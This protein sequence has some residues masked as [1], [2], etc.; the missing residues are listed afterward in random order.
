MSYNNDM[1]VNMLLLPTASGLEIID[2][3]SLVRVE[4][5]SNYSRLFFA[6]GKTL[7]VAKVLAWFEDQLSCK[8]FLR[9]HRSHLVNMQF[10]Q[11]L[12]DVRN[13]I[14]ILKNNE[15]IPISKRKKQQCKMVIR[16]FYG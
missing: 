9:L 13:S 2:C 7:V 1:P 11:K 8:G 6:N 14:A 4:A 3:L 12:N 16:Q 15:N 10:I 5:I